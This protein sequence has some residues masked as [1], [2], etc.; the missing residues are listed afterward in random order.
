MAVVDP[1]V[2][3]TIATQA[4]PKKKDKFLYLMVVMH[5]SLK[6]K[7]PI[8]KIAKLGHHF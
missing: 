3:I 6:I 4:C 8:R 2:D 1:V 7:T 5:C